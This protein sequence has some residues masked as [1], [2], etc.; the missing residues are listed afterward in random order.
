MV[1]ATSRQLRIYQRSRRPPPPPP[2][3]PPP[4]PPPS[5]SLRGRLASIGRAS[6]TVSERPP[7]S[8]P[9]H[10]A[11]AFSASSSFSNSTKPN[12]RDRPDILSMTTVAVATVPAWA[13]ASR[14]SSLVVENGNPPTYN[15]L[16]IFFIR[17]R[18]STRLNSSH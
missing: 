7:K 2:P 4:P 3:N 10:I 17:D 9:F 18:K 13:N 15:F 14:N 1:L 12:P 16:A 5:R 8:L 6:F 11:I